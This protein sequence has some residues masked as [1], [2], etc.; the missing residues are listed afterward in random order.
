MLCV[1]ALGIRKRK[2]LRRVLGLFA[3]VL[4]VVL[5]PS[6]AY[7]HSGRTDANGGH[8][9][10]K[11]KSGLG[12]YHYHCGGN[13]PHLHE[14]GVCPYGDGGTPQQSTYTPPSPKVNLE[15]YP[16]QMNV[17]DSSGLEYSIENATDS[18]STVSSSNEA[19]LRVNEDGT[20]SAV[21]AG[22]AT[23]TVSG[24]G[25]EQSFEVTVRTVPV[26]S[27]SVL[28]LPEELQLGLTSQATAEVLPENATD[29]TVE[30]KSSDPTIAE[31][32]SDGTVT[33]VS[34]GTVT[35]ICRASN[36]VEAQVPLKVYEVFPDEIK[37][38]TERIRL[39][40]GETQTVNIEILPEHANN[41]KYTVKI[42][43][44]SVAMLKKGNT[45]E[46]RK[47]G[48]T[49]LVIETENQLTKRI[50]VFVYHIPVQT[51]TIDDSS[52]EYV[53][54]AFMKHAVD[55][56]TSITLGT[57]LSPENATYTDIVWESSDPEVISASE[58]KLEVCGTGD[59]VLSAVS[60]DGTKDTIELKVVSSDQV[61]RAIGFVVTAAAGIVVLLIVI[62]GKRLKAA[63]KKSVDE[64]AETDS[65]E[66]WEGN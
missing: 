26:G 20:L 64:T 10:Y 13:P 21:A 55:L 11:N 62:G 40:V 47:D 52:L 34:P 33:A 37:T 42:E 31:I 54:T 1:K 12:S 61:N 32:N 23:I 28:N 8:H 15:T 2:L 24:S 4:C 57:K 46:A 6:A 19:V 48:I 59:V 49:D 14:N 53:Y 43:D 18:R 45:I 22:T 39:N 38:D 63:K 27:V 50:P 29:R 41:K 3:I 16:T 35:I 17:G 36:G 44:E 60:Y 25:V 66:N 7:A 51:V 9:D 56:N 65:G 5:L 58:G 30:W